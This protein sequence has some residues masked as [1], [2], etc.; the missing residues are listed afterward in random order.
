[1]QTL[2]TQTPEQLIYKDGDLTIEVL[3]GIRL[4]RLD[5]L[6]VTLK[7]EYENTTYRHTLDLYND[8]QV[9]KLI[10][11][12]A[13]KLQLGMGTITDSIEA[14]TEELEQYRL[15]IREE[16]NGNKPKAIELTKEEIKQAE[17]L[18]KTKDLLNH[19]NILIGK[20]GVIGEE[21]NRL[22]MYIIFTSRKMSN[23]LH[24]ISMGASGTGK[25]HLQESV[26]SLIPEEDT[27]SV[28]D[29]SESSFY[30]FDTNELSHKLMLIEDLDG[31]ESALYPLRELQS[32]KTITK[33]LVERKVS[34]Q[35]TVHRTVHG[36]V[37]VAGCTTKEQVYE[38]NANR[39]FLIYIDQSTAQDQKIMQFQR[40][41]SA[42]KIN[43][44]EQQQIRTLLKNSQRILK[45]LKVVNPYAEL[46]ELPSSVFKPRRTNAHYL[47]FIEAVTFYNQYQREI[48]VDKT[49]GEEYITTDI[50]DIKNANDLLKDILI[51]KSDQLSPACR[52]YFERL[53]MYL[54]GE[55]TTIFTNR[56]ISFKLN[57][58][59]PTIKRYHKELYDKH[60]LKIKKKNK[61]QGFEYEIVSYEE[62]RQLQ[63]NVSSI[64]DQTLDKVL[65]QINKDKKI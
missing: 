53:K 7:M 59:L 51:K 36:P 25:S 4:D 46:L 24:I 16:Q 34:G 64:L 8:I 15:D 19:T 32:K 2:N 58:S 38:D 11:R 3:G 42:G 37:C 14:L 33:T 63:E 62:Y 21:N 44:L 28:T 18:L 13:G 39:S 49:T 57:K 30:Y 12:S 45:P 1:M 10:R 6:R 9:T 5:G 52:N 31:A 61:Q 47:H 60:F 41:L 23:P 20:S 29:L 43:T 50:E 65:K 54:L 48:K 55:K 22:L 26:A 56:Q 40:Q 27:L 17:K 35:K